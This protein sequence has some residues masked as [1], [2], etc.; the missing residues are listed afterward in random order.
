MPTCIIGNYVKFTVLCADPQIYLLI[1][2]FSRILESFELHFRFSLM[3][4]PLK[5]TSKRLLPIMD[6]SANNFFIL[7][8]LSIM[9]LL[10]ETRQLSSP[11]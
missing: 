1:C 4:V 9:V 7:F 3:L 5:E 11:S 2:T 10:M 8:V 6:S